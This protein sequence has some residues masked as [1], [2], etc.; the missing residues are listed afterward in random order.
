VIQLKEVNEVDANKQVITSLYNQL[1]A[2]QKDNSSL[3]QEN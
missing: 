1:S 3:C 2:I